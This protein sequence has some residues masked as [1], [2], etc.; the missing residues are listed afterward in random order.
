MCGIAG[1][2]L[3]DGRPVDRDLVR[4][5]T[6]TLR[7]RGPDAE[8]FY[9]ARGVGLGHRRLSIVDLS[10]GQQPFVSTSGRIAVVVN[11]EIYNHASLRAEL[12]RRGHRFKTHSDC[13]VVLHGYEEEG[14]SF[15][16]RLNGMFALA[17]WDGR[18]PHGRLVLARDRM[19]QKPLH[20]A[21]LPGGGLAFGSELK[22]LFAHPGVD[23]AVSPGAL[24][25][26]LVYEYV[27]APYTIVKG[28]RKLLPGH[29]LV[30]SGKHDRVHTEAYWQLPLGKPLDEPRDSVVDH[31][32]ALLRRSVERR[33]M[34]DV[35]LG[36]FLSGGLDSSSVLASLAQLTDP[37]RIRTFTISFDD[38]TFD[39]SSHAER[40]ARHFGT[41]HHA[42]VLR[43]EDALELIPD[44]ADWLDEP[45]GDGS[46]VP[47]YLL[48]RST[49]RHVKVALGGDGAD[50]LLGGYPTFV[51]DHAARWFE[52]LPV[53]VRRATEEVVDLLPVSLANFSLDFKARSFLEG[54]PF[55]GLHR[56]QV[57][58]GSFSP[59]TLPKVLG[60]AMR[61]HLAMDDPYLDLDR[62][63]AG[64]KPA[65]RMDRLV[66][67]YTRFYLAD[68]ILTKIDR[69][70]MAC[71]LEVRSPF[72]DPELVDFAARLPDQW[73][74]SGRA[75]KRVL[76]LAMRDLLPDSVITRP[77]KGFG[78]PVA[79][80]LHREL[81]PLMD[82]LL[83]PRL[84]ERQGFLDG[85]GVQTLVRE[86]LAGRADHRKP[87]WTLIVLQL[88]LER[89]GGI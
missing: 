87:L 29:F 38:R 78:M 49:R 17:I 16:K 41:D 72:L 83:D 75:T 68:D 69:A 86:H 51:A 46:L 27:P 57:W 39:E 1:V 33:L 70:S 24:L 10:G 55:R 45:F 15:F 37:R 21:I 26:Y 12:V 14:T 82:R 13:E 85:A 64:L 7:R 8:G 81:R 56:H 20:F 42:E 34:A 47:T 74:V 59:V 5:M 22:A 89:Y 79:R 67:Y 71:S 25:R 32:R 66:A 76:R 9:F 35:P 30:W 52:R 44:I 48:S 31:F 60:P 88:W 53:P 65:S 77:K 18:V 73:K 80:W 50:E 43:P 61:E 54:I 3:P 6:A 2:A 40:V 4:R 58:L 28:A 62:R 19:G 36:V 23:R 63:V 11:G 84:L